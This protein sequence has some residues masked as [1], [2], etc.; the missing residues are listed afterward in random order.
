MFALGVV[1]RGSYTIAAENRWVSPFWNPSQVT[2]QVH[3]KPVVRKKAA[4][5]NELNALLTA[6]F[7]SLVCCFQACA[8]CVFVLGAFFAAC[9]AWPAR[10]QRDDRSKGD[11]TPGSL[12]PLA[13][14]HGRDLPVSVVPLPHQE[15]ASDNCELL[16]D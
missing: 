3:F 8:P 2:A 16:G 4:K 15:W 7:G 10:W 6:L 13:G 14:V 12:W 1:L 11:S 9:L 5:G